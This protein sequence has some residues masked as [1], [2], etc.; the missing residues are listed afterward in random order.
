MKAFLLAA[1][2][3][4]RLRPLTN[5]IPKC[6]I[7]IDGKPMLYYWFQLL[8]KHNINNVL[9]N[10]HHLP[11]IVRKYVADF[12]SLNPDFRITLFYEEELAGSAGTIRANFQWIKNEREF[13]IAYADNLTN[14]NLTKLIK[15]HRGK[16]AILTMGLFRSD[17][18]K[19]CGIAV[20]DYSGLIIEFVEKPE[21]PVSDL[22]N[23]GIYVASPALLDYIPEGV[24]DLGHDVLPELVGEMYGYEF[25]LSH[26]YI[27]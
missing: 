27:Y 21:N 23:A 25:G 10:L 19:G 17:Y 12:S 5:T 1:G 6:M 8:K 9:I 11:D 4:T 7:P 14:V 18:P 20:L 15:F 13:L 16:D 22:A 2:L 3:G 24:A 26:A